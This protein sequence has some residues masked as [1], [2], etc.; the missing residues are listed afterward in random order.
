MTQRLRRS[1]LALALMLASAFLLPQ[2]AEAHGFGQ[3]YDLPVP[4]WLYLV[5]AGG[6]VALSFVVIG[7]FVRGA[8]GLH[9]YPRLNLL[10]WRVGRALVHPAVVLPIKAASVLLFVVVVAAGSVGDQRL[11]QNLAPTFVWVVWWVGL[12]YASALVGNLWVLINP[13]NISFGWVETLWRLGFERELSFHLRYPDKLGVWPGLLLFLVF[14]WMELVYINSA[15]P[16]RIAQAALVYSAITWGG[17][18]L[19]GKEQ[20]LRRGEAFSLA[21]GFLAR[22]APTEIR[23]IDPA[24]CD[25]CKLECRDL[26]GECIGCGD[27]FRRASTERRE[28]NMRP[29][30]VGLVRN[31]VVSTSMMAFVVLLLSTV[32][33]DGFTATPV[34]VRIFSTLYTVA[35]NGT[36]VRTLGLVALPVV[37]LGVYL[38][39]AALMAVA[40]GRRLPVGD[41][42]RAFIYSLVPIALAYHLAHYLSFLLIQGQLIIPLASDPFGLGWNLLGTNGYTVNIAIINARYAWFTAIAAI[43]TGHIIAVYLAHVI[44]LRTLKERKPALS[45]Q[46]P[47]LVLMVGYTMISLWILAQPLVE[48]VRKG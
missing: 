22:F 29:F 24:V 37:F 47:M 27:C 3:R 20:W 32:T 43:V 10:R 42:A 23:V 19:F 7:L 26:D 6:A 35:P 14:T 33:F 40:S 12:A 39:F 28:L 18:L 31:E 8:P 38:R 2:A 48:T 30:G 15:L 46:Y 13:W 44:A 36:A 45:S 16:A 41:M 25:Q 34:W 4:L 9:G 17:M 11:T 21:F 1:A 5:G